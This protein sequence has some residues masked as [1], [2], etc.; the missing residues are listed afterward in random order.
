MIQPINYDTIQNHAQ[1]YLNFS[2]QTRTLQRYF[3]KQASIDYQLDSTQM[4]IDLH[5][6]LKDVG[7]LM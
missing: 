3:G 2:E 1:R 5:Y 4:L 7:T 6:P